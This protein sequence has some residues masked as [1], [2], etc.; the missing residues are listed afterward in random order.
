MLKANIIN[1]NDVKLLVDSFYA[2]VKEDD[3]LA[4]IFDD[5]IKDNWPF[6]LEKMYRFWQ[7]I[8]LDEHTYNGRPFV[9]HAKLPIDK[10]HFDRWLE[11]FYLTV[12]EN[13][14]GEKAYEAKWRA[15]K[16]AEMFLNKI[17]YYKNNPD[18]IAI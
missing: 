11:L 18:K 14:V 2:K 8:L 16:M 13:F 4:K 6:H 9:P 5:V 15:D 3:L 7:T 12:D 17:K 10:I 1:I